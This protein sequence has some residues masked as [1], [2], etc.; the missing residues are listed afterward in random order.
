VSRHKINTTSLATVVDRVAAY[1]DHTRVKLSAEGFVA[2][3]IPAS[4]II[5]L[6]DWIVADSDSASTLWLRGMHDELTEDTD[7][8]MTMLAAKFIELTGQIKLPSGRSMPCVSY[9]C[10]IKVRRRRNG[11]PSPEAQGLVEI[12]YGLISQLASMLDGSSVVKQELPVEALDGTLETWDDALQV[13][14]ALLCS[15]TPGML[16]VIDGLHWLDGGGVDNR[17]VDLVKA[18]RSSPMMLLFT[19]SARSGALLRE[20]PSDEVETFES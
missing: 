3:S 14:H 9:F 20:I 12:L 6:H 11:G 4:A 10:H 16:C 15:V 5:R 18:L 1:F 2:A 7:N 8:A 13:V 19:T 17:V